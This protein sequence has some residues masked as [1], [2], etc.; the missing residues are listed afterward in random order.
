MLFLVPPSLPPL[1]PASQG[2][3]GQ[4][5]TPKATPAK[6]AFDQAAIR[7]LEAYDAG[8][9]I[10]PMPP[11]AKADQPAYRWLRACTLA[12]AG[13]PP[14][15]P[16]PAGPA[17][18]EAEA[19]RRLVALKPAEA[20]T[21]LPQLKTKE[22]GTWMGLWRWGKSQ[23]RTGAWDLA[24]RRAWEDRLLA[25]KGLDL[26]QGYALRHALCFA[27][28]EK[29]EQ[30]LGALRSVI[31]E[32]QE[33]LYTLAQALFGQLGHPLPVVRLWS[34]P[35]LRFADRPLGALGGNRVWI[36]PFE[37]ALPRIP[38]GCT[39]VVPTLGGMADPADATLDEVST[40]EA[41]PVITALE[42]A[43]ATAW[44]APSRADFERMGLVHFPIFLRFDAEGRLLEVRMGD[45]AP[46]E[47]GF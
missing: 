6:V 27:I 19:F 21:H 28:A 23:A 20:V 40:V 30:R 25:G 13:H 47:P 9:G 2:I 22:L 11:L 29:D 43:F 32:E 16:F 37:G 39:W 36:A 46:K 7:L 33:E 5:P 15:N 8:R 38:P 34:L 44:L 14:E 42:K 41:R 1:A 31:P 10:P 24:Q 26:I 4:A 45:A 12:K 18:E 3:H 35:G 17:R